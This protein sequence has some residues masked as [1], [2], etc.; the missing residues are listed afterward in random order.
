ML[1][2]EN[3]E[4]QET[5]FVAV[6]RYS[7]KYSILNFD[8]VKIYQVRTT[9]KIFEKVLGNVLLIRKYTLL[10]RQLNLEQF[11]KFMEFHQYEDN[12]GFLREL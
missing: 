9:S 2:L 11:L 8:L 6:N 3:W 4:L 1:V 10:F 7:I 12:Y 5:H